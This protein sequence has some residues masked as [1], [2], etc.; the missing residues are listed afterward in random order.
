MRVVMMGALIATL[1]IGATAAPASAQ[2]P[3][4]SPTVTTYTSADS[5]LNLRKVSFE[6]GKTLDLSVGIGSGAFRAKGDPDTVFLTISDRGPNFTCGDAEDIIG[7]KGDKICG[8]I[9]RGRI[10]PVPEYNPSIY[11]VQVLENGTFRVL[12]SLSLKDSHGNP[13]DGLLNPLTVASTEQPLDAQGR[14]LDRNPNSVDAEGIVRLSDGGFWIGDE[15][16]PSILHAAPDGRIL[17]RHVPAGTE[18]DYAKADYKVEGTLPALL[19]TRALNRGIESMAL[20]DDERFLWFVLQNPLANPD[21][22]TYVAANAARLF[23]FDR[24]AGRIAGEYVYR[25][26]PT[27]AYRG[28]EKKKQNTVRISE[29]TYLSGDTLL[30][31]ER[32]ELTTKIYRIDLSGATDIAG[33]KWDDAATKPSLE[34]V[35]LDEAG[36]KPAA[37]TLVL[38]TADHT[39]IPVKVEGMARF[40]DGSLMLIN[41]DDFGIDGKRTTIVKVTGLALDDPKRGN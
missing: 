16:G 35:K 15:N 19:A 36:I 7:V 31:L 22:D 14:K 20:S 30:I 11:R 32:T 10:Y 17:V 29:L 18:K 5:I 34:Q 6:G 3:A 39:E 8:D 26:E 13:V 28:E 41:D 38:D 21:N 9:K 37:K 4:Q 24:E 33:G 40:G 2:S 23:K 27:S 12:D 1:S 25:M